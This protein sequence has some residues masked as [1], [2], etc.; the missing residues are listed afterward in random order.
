MT[1]KGYTLVELIIV[2]AIIG[3]LSAIAFT[4]LYGA[5]ARENT[6]N[7][8]LEIRASLRNMEEQALASQLNTAG[9]PAA[10]YGVTLDAAFYQT[11]RIEKGNS[12]PVTPVATTLTQSTYYPPGVTITT[13]PTFRYI[14][15]TE[16]K[17]GVKFYDSA[18]NAVGAAADGAVAVTV[19]GGANGGTQTVKVY[20]ATGRIE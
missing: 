11:I 3:I 16:N 17:A 10:E 20:Q 12:G 2:I 8:A 1:E 6:R 18:G 7:T 19:S 15:F 14:T 4:G 5:N 13:T 9:N